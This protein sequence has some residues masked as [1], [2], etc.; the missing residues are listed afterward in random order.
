MKIDRIG[1][2]LYIHR[3]TALQCS[4]EGSIVFYISDVKGISQTLH[5]NS[6][7]LFVLGA[8]LS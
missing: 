2:L 3:E 7:I 6:L 1:I 4:D 5:R 8:Y